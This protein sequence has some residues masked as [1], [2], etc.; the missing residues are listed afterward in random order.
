VAANVYLIA[1]RVLVN[2]D[3]P[4][5]LVRLKRRLN[6]AVLPMI[7]DKNLRPRVTAGVGDQN[8]FWLKDPEHRATICSLSSVMVKK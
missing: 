5:T 6:A 1:L 2:V 3:I 7:H 4:H 8:P